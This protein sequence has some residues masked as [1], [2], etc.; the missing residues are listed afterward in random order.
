MDSESN[1]TNA[2]YQQVTVDVPEDR[3][4]E[5]H[6]LFARFLAGPMGR[7]RRGRRGGPHRYGRGHGHGCARRHEAPEAPGTEQATETTEV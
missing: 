4:A 7:G 1:P 3:L 6:A 2:Q 5:F